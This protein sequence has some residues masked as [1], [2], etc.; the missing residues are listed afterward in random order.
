M[1]DQS[2]SAR[3]QSLFDSALQ[4]YGVK[5]GVPLT[6]H[7]L[8][9]DLQSCQSVD[10]ITALLQCQVQAFGDFQE[11]DRMMTVIKTTVSILTPL[12]HV[13]SLADAVGAV[14]Q[15]ALMACST[16]FDFFFQ[17]SFPPAKAIQASL[18]ILLDVCTVLSSIVDIVVTSKCTQTAN[19]VISSCHV[20]AD[21]LESIQHFVDRLKVYTEIS[22][23]PSINKIAVGLIVELI[24][25]LALVTRKLNQRRSSEFLLTDL[26]HYSARNSHSGKELFCGQGHQAGPAA[27]GQ[28][29]ARRVSE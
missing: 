29:H 27:V 18:G 24:S 15:K 5:T 17:T 9:V 19:G 4:D 21:L 10:D 26:L 1:A 25:T 8:A 20:L 13:V 11:K 6:Q 3:F 22:P 28:T 16:F 7:P 12:S 14:R 23:T 2:G